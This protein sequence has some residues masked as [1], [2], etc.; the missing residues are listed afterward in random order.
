MKFGYL[1][2]GGLLIVC[3]A[4][5]PAQ[6]LTAKTLTVTLNEYGDARADMQYDLSFVEQ[7]AIFLHA[8]NPASTLQTALEENLNRPVRV[9]S[10]D[11]SAA[12]VI[13]PGFATV[14]QLDGA[15]TMTTPAFSFANAQE[16]IKN[17]WYAPFIS[18]DFAPQTTTITFPNGYTVTY[19]DQI[20]IPSVSRTV[21]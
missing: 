13:I 16:A 5:M 15:T 7:A 6:A 19:N 10:A 3:L 12:E 20:S 8:A 14:A 2:L 9:I 11:S 17:K 1:F 21:A 18:A 4:V